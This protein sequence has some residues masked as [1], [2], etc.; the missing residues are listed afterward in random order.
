[1]CM[2]VCPVC[3]LRGDTMYRLGSCEGQKGL[4]DS[5]KLQLKTIV[6]HCVFWEKNPG[7]Q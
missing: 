5:L 6:S 1:M 7:T 2:I 4:T 3:V